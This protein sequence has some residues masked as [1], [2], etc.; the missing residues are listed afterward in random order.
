MTSAPRSLGWAT[1]FDVAVASSKLFRN[2]ELCSRGPLLSRQGI[3][4]LESRIMVLLFSFEPSRQLGGAQICFSGIQL[5]LS[6]LQRQ[7]YS[8]AV[9]LIIQHNLR[10]PPRHVTKADIKSVVWST[11]FGTYRWYPHRSKP[12][13]I[14]SMAFCIFCSLHSHRLHL[15]YTAYQRN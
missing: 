4:R 3:M 6:R 1:Q 2:S 15:L 8:S 10:I 12:P 11:I 5:L 9:T 14:W 7:D 13:I